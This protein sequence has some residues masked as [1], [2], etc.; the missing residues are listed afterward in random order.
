M[1]VEQKEARIRTF[2]DKTWV[3]MMADLAAFRNPTDGE[4][5]YTA[6]IL[7]AVKLAREDYYSSALD[8]II[9]CAEKKLGA[10]QSSGA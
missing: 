7:T 3:D 2:V 9:A 5:E 10:V 1:T 4:R 6:D 8:V